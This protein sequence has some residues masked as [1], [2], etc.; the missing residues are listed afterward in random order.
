MVALCREKV[1]Y[2][3]NIPNQKKGYCA[4]GRTMGKRGQERR[5]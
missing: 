4:V 5:A 2:A 1:D 3:R